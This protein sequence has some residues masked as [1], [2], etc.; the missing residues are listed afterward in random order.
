MTD[1]TSVTITVNGISLTGLAAPRT[2]LA[3]FLRD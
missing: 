1:R 3:D 2:L